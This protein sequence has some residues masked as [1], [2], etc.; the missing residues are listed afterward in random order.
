MS[1]APMT[2][3]TRNDDLDA[4]LNIIHEAESYIYLSVM[5]YAPAI[6]SY[7]LSTN[8]NAQNTRADTV[9]LSVYELGVFL[10]Y[11]STTHCASR[12]FLVVPV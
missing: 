11:L 9:L 5:S 12:F 4:I 2:P 8:N 3:P 1:P 7:S 6:I 10:A